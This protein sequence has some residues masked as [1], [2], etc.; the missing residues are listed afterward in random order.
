MPTG[1]QLAA[2][3]EGRLDVGII[4]PSHW[5]SP[6]AGMSV[7]RLWRD[8]LFVF[9]PDD[10]PLVRS[11]D[12]IPV[13]ALAHESFVC[14]PADVGCGLRE[15]LEMLCSQAG[16]RPRIAMEVNPASAILGLVAAGVGVAILPECQ[17]LAGIAG[18]IGRR[19]AADRVTS[20]LLLAWRNRDVSPLLRCFLQ[21]VDEL[22]PA[23]GLRAPSKKA[24]LP[25]LAR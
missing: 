6:P 17:M 3:E 2:L 21:V 4:R 23:Q 16:F 8:E 14:F 9:L 18:V 24:A 12:A 13:E 7:Q 19:L 15:H 25:P 22:T 20:D 10:H 1:E 11:G 5:F